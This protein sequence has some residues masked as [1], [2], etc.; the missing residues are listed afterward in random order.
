MIPEAILSRIV[1]LFLILTGAVLFGVI[2]GT[3]TGD[4]ILL[5]LSLALA[6]AGGAKV[7]TLFHSVRK[8]DYDVAEGTVTSIKRI[9]VRKC[10]VLTL[11]D[12]AG[13]TTEICIR[14]RAPFTLGKRYRFFLSREVLDS[15]NI[16]KSELLRPARALLGF[17]ETLAGQ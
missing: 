16:P 12:D 9:P 7:W 17:E 2:Y 4:R 8:K 14:G 6:A 1:R 10:H 3:V 13:E 11:T 15:G 5:L